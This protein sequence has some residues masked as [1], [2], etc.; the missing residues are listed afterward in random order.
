[1]K[2]WELLLSGF[3]LSAIFVLVYKYERP[4]W[5]E[6]KPQDGAYA[7][8]YVRGGNV[9]GE[10]YKAD[11]KDLWVARYGRCQEEMVVS[12]QIAKKAVEAYVA[13]PANPAFAEDCR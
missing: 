12:E 11:V 2:H 6:G 10:V 8:Y 13:D 4:A 7:E 9:I 1:M 5:I 3:V